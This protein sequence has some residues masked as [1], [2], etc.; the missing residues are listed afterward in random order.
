MLSIDR[1]GQPMMNVNGF[2][3]KLYGNVMS[4]IHHGSDGEQMET[5]YQIDQMSELIGFLRLAHEEW[6]REN[7][8]LSSFQKDSD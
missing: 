1:T 2:A 8:T 7:I 3:V 4:I 6:I 5:S